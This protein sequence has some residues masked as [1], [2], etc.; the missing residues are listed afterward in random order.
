[1]F[2]KI[3]KFEKI[4]SIS[5]NFC[6]AGKSEKLIPLSK[7]EVD[8][9]FGE[10]LNLPKKNE[11]KKKSSHPIKVRTMLFVVRLLMNYVH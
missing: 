4:G 8:H 1:M 5:I 3:T 7:Q 6:F 10:K 9:V 2:D 11:K